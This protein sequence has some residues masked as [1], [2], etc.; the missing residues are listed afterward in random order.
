[1]PLHVDV[2]PPGRPGSSNTSS[3]KRPV[4]QHEDGMN[5]RGRSNSQRHCARAAPRVLLSIRTALMSHAVAQDRSITTAARARRGSGG[6]VGWRCRT[7]RGPPS[8]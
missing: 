7:A 1:V 5:A 2:P 3:M 4:E 8:W 6:P